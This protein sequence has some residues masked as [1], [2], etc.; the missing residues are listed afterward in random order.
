MDYRKFGDKYLIRLDRG[1]EIV[2]SISEICR[3][4]DIKLGQIIG[5]GT[6]NHAQLGLLETSTKNYYPEVFTTDNEI[7]SIIGTVSRKDGEVYLHIHM[8]MANPDHEVMGGHLDYA[9]V[10]A[11]AEILIIEFDGTAGRV[12]SDDVGVNLLTFE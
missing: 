11:V 7:T 2:E 10:S 4:N 12:W 3:E 9:V 8:S 5:F 1:E 6:T